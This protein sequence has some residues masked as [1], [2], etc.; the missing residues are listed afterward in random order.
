ML[1]VFQ[2]NIPSLRLVLISGM[3]GWTNKSPL[4]LYNTLSPIG[5]L[6][7][8]SKLTFKGWLHLRNPKLIWSMSLLP[9]GNSH[10]FYWTLLIFRKFFT[11]SLIDGLVGRQ[12]NHWTNQHTGPQTQLLKEMW[13]LIIKQDK[14]MKKDDRKILQNS[15]ENV[16]VWQPISWLFFKGLTWNWWRF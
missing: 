4:V 5:L 16:C 14:T 11:I 9:K 6:T 8:F 2:L 15:H 3:I 12:T 13:G 7:C 1:P 10:L